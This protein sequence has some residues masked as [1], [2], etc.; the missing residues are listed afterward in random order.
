M[1]DEKDHYKTLHVDPEADPDVITAAFRTLSK[2][3]HPETDFTGIQE[4]RLAELTRAYKILHDPAE[5]KAYDL[6]RAYRLRAVGPGLDEDE[7]EP[8]SHL[9]ERVQ[10]HLSGVDAGAERR[11]DFGRYAGQSL[12]EIANVDTEYLRWLSRHSSGIRFRN[13]IIKLLNERVVVPYS[14]RDSR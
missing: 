10:A 12:R 8:T 11:L 9:A 5:R 14:S 3:L 6:R 7:I 13:E 2:K 1:R 4:Y